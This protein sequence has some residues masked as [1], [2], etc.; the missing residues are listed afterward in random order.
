M[1]TGP[2]ID[3]GRALNRL[4]N[5][6]WANQQNLRGRSGFSPNQ[7]PS[8]PRSPVQPTRSPFP[9]TPPNDRFRPGYIPSP[10]TPPAPARPP[11]PPM[12]NTPV[13][14]IP[15]PPP[16]PFNANG[17]L[18]KASSDDSR[19]SDDNG[20]LYRGGSSTT[21]L[22][23][24]LYWRRRQLALQAEAARLRAAQTVP[25]HEEGME[26]RGDNEW[27]PVPQA[28]SNEGSVV[29]PMEPPVAKVLSREQTTEA[30]CESSTSADGSKVALPVVA[31]PCTDIPVKIHAEAR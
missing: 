28:D 2:D 13:Y 29:A 22:F 27:T 17:P 8:Y 14:N 25:M 20:N 9:P 11:F 18:S 12:P 1:R 5:P 10:P 23:L 4:L 19:P 30:D 16:P 24:Y 21:M 3:R 15:P 7:P 26:H 6:E 31:Y